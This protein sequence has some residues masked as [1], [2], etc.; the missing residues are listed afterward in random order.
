MADRLAQY[1]RKRDFSKTS[2]PRGG[3]RKRAAHALRFV[4]QKHAARRLHY[5]FRLEMDGVLKS[6]AVPKGPSLDPGVKR[7]AVKVE[8]HPLDYRDFEGVIPEGE[9][10]GGAVIVWDEGTWVPQGEGDPETALARGALK[11]DLHGKRLN[12]GWA[13]VRL[14]RGNGKNWL[15][16]KEKDEQARPGSDHELVE[17]NRTSVVSGRELEEVAEAPDRVWRSNSAAPDDDR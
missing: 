1:R 9:Y 2:E 7:L 8:D 6:W 12:G 5:D 4:V 17:E 13:L 14:R 10:G 3:R 11:F 16:V 15:L